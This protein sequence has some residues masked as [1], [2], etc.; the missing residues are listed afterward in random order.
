[1]RERTLDK[2]AWPLAPGP[3]HLI[4]R[5]IVLRGLAVIYFSAFYS[6]AFQ[7]Q[8]LIG[9]NGILPVDPYLRELAQ[10]FS[11]VELY[12][13]APTLLWFSSGAHALTALWVVGMIASVLLFFNLWPRGM[14]AICFI[15]FLSF[16]TAAQDFSSYQSDGMLLEAGFIALFFAPPGFRPGLG[17]AHPPSRLSYFLLQWEW[18]RIYFESGLVKMLS[19]DPQWK[20]LTAMDEYYQN[21]P[22]PTWIGWYVERLPHW[23]HAATAGGTL[24]LELVV[25]W[26]M[27]LPRRWR[28]VLFCIVTPWEIGIILTANY[29]FLNYLVLLL[30]VL[31]LDDRL[32]AP[33]I[34]KLPVIGSRAG[35]ASSAPTNIITAPGSGIHPPVRGDGN[36]LARF[37]APLR[38]ARMVAEGFFL[39]WVFYATTALLIGIVVPR[40]PPPMAPATLLEPFRIANRFGLFAVMTRGRYEIEF[41]GSRDG[42]TWIAYPFRYK[43][44][45]PRAA[46][47]IYAPYQP[48]FEWN[49]WFASLEPWRQN[50]WVLSVQ[51]QLLRNDSAVLSLF[52]GNPF[53]AQPPVQVR[54]ILWQYWFSTAEEKKTQGVWWRREQRELFSPTIQRESDGNFGVVQMPMAFPVSPE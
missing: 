44:Q 47:G 29:A 41:Q 45:D 8:G 37:R 18:F 42:K 17:A 32:L 13:Y 33:L 46:P 25:V 36:W 26:M 1:M 7:I 48:R 14:L 19:G 31:L 23:F 10:H 24:A 3:D 21:G 40:D 50:P 22:L 30:G 52:A 51:E 27:F 39:G 16:I 53:G 2:L 34:D 6:C 11:G 5:W 49:L 35:A 54:A 9:P 20:H 12:W 15:A 4:P 28:M 38:T 43:P